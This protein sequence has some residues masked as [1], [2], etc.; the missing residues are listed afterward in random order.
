M[1]M[2]VNRLH[3]LLTEQVDV[4]VI[5]TRFYLTNPSQGKH[6]YDEGHIE[7]AVY[8]DLDHDLSG[9]KAAHGGRHPLPDVTVFAAKLGK[10]GVQAGTTVVVYDSGQGMAA[11][12]WWLIRFMGHD[13]VHILDGG[14]GAWIREGYDIT[15]QSPASRAA[16]FV[17]NVRTEWLVSMEEVRDIASGKRQGTL[18][19]ARARERFRGDVEPLDP[20]AG[21]IPLAHNLP[22]T[23]GLEASG[24]WKKVEEQTERFEPFQGAQEIVMYCG[25]GVTACNNLFALE[26]TG[27]TG[28]LYAGSWSDWSSYADNPV[29]VGDSKN[30]PRIDESKEV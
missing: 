19:D 28:K 26:L 29:E 16:S 8:F 10:V 5:D 1:L 17:P 23:E 22:F 12:A 18:I 25:S 9:S 13:N 11:R 2:S 20:K 4:V 21:H 7:G 14:L 24:L 15:T 3:Q 6:E 27:R 30:S